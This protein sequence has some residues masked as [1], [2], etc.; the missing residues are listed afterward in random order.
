MTPIFIIQKKFHIKLVVNEI[1]A[2]KGSRSLKTEILENACIFP[3]LSI[4][5]F[6]LYKLLIIK[7]FNYILIND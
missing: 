4:F 7:Q 3:Y 6:R 1:S 5:N 2:H